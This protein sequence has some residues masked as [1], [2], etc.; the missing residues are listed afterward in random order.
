[1]MS[2]S[3]D[4]KK[5]LAYKLSGDNFTLKILNIFFYFIHHFQR[6]S[7]NNENKIF[8][9]GLLSTTTEEELRSFFSSFGKVH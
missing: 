4:N 2:Q 3:S 7:G 8:V 6:D 1:M 5:L 9:G